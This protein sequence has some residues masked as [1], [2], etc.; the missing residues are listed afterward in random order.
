[1]LG[2]FIN[3]ILSAQA[4]T[5]CGADYG[6][7]SDNCVNHRNG[8]RHRVLDT[9]VGTVDNPY[10]TCLNHRD[11]HVLFKGC[12]YPQDERPGRHPRHHEPIEVTNQ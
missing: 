3:Q 9:R 11:R 12:V 6:T 5:V 10:R 8:Y 4:D 2:D 1:M 7:T